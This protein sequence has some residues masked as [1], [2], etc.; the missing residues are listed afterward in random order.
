MNSIDVITLPLGI[1]G[2]VA[3]NPVSTFYTTQTIKRLVESNST[4]NVDSDTGETID[5]DSVGQ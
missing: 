4:Y 2:T 1:A 3:G 5:I